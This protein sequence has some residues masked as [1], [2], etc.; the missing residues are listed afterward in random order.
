MYVIRTSPME[1]DQ[2]PPA[3]WE[4][5]SV[6]SIAFKAG[7][8]HRRNK[9]FAPFKG[10]KAST[11]IPC[12]CRACEPLLMSNPSTG[13]SLAINSQGGAVLE[14]LYPDNTDLHTKIFPMWY[15]VA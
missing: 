11:F 6:T 13:M 1:L 7:A 4:G 12:C 2:R 15:K 14:M 10:C 5:R 9:A 3:E 8:K